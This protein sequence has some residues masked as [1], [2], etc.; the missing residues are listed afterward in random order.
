MGCPSEKLCC[1][2]CSKL[3]YCS[4]SY[5]WSYVVRV[6]AIVVVVVVVLIVVVVIVIVVVVMYTFR[7][8]MILMKLPWM[9]SLTDITYEN[10]A[11]MCL[12]FKC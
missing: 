8:G 10:Q 12:V 3:K 6:I 5:L 1:T 4:T 7:R 11:H 2:S 9:I